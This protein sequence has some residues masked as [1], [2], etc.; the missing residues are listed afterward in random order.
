[1]SINNFIEGGINNTIPQNLETWSSYPAV[2]NVD[3]NYKD[4]LDT[5]DIVSNTITTTTGNISSL[6]VGGSSVLTGY[7][8]DVNGSGIVRQNMDV[9]GILYVGRPTGILP[10]GTTIAGKNSTSQNTLYLEN[11][12]ANGGLVIKDSSDPSYIGTNTSHKF[13]LISN[14]LIGATLDISGNLGIGTQ[15]PECRLHLNKNT[16]EEIKFKLTNSSNLNGTEII[17]DENGSMSIVNRNTSTTYGFMRFITNNTWERMR[18]TRNGDVGINNAYP[19][20]KV[21]INGNT[22]TTGAFYSGSPTSLPAGT[23]FGGQSGGSQAI[24]YLQNNNAQGAFA[25]RDSA[26]LSYIGTYTTHKFHIITNNSVRSTYDTAG[27]VGIGTQTPSEKLDVAGNVNVSGNV[28]IGDKLS[29]GISSQNL[30]LSSTNTAIDFISTTVP[31][32]EYMY[33]IS[34]SSASDKNVNIR[35]NTTGLTKS[36]NFI[37]CFIGHTANLT[38]VFITTH[39][40]NSLD[41]LSLTNKLVPLSGVITNSL[42][43]SSTNSTDYKVIKFTYMAT[44][45]GGYVIQNQ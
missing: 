6:S 31:Y 30:S 4:L 25:I 9:S 33:F 17:C 29:G 3:M 15:S 26:N 7:K 16:A 19:S 35:I 32:N 39:S 10:T 18:I 28:I 37:V 5:D 45:T 36:F 21:D 40:S 27:N 44:A 41:T 2:S 14:N 13:S 11:G 12:T 38:N 20:H 43:L 1:M 42:T 8:L 23:T 22:R 34:N 24:V